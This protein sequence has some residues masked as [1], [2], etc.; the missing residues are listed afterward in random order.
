[1]NTDAWGQMALLVV[2]AAML[3]VWAYK[4]VWRGP[5]VT[6]ALVVEKT[7]E[8]AATRLPDALPGMGGVF[9]ASTTNILVLDVSGKKLRYTANDESWKRVQ[10]GD[11]VK[12]WV[13]NETH[14][15][16]VYVYSRADRTE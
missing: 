3:G 6:R 10:A 13:Q 1:M 7:W 8:E 15:V 5:K 4:N 11:D 12:V 16:G 14:V 9:N 2:G